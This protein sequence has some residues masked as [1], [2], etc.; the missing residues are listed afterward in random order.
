[1]ATLLRNGG[2]PERVFPNIYNALEKG[3]TT[4]AKTQQDERTQNGIKQILATG[5]GNYQEKVTRNE[6]EPVRM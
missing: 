6:T 4:A 1:M 3:E 5:T 2:N